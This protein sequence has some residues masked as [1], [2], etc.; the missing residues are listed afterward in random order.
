MRRGGIKLPIGLALGQGRLGLS[1]PP[2]K[3]YPPLPPRLARAFLRCA[4]CISWSGEY[5]RAVYSLIFNWC[6]ERIRLAFR[7]HSS[8]GKHSGKGNSV[9]L[10]RKKFFHNHN[11]VPM[12]IP[13]YTTKQAFSLRPCGGTRASQ[14]KRFATPTGPAPCRSE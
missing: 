1:R 10:F 3:G 4:V 5:Q 9:S 13:L 12:R 11:I 2:Q 14:F 7:M 6:G 8:G